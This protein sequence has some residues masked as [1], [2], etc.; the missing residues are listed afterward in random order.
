MIKNKDPFVFW[1]LSGI[2]GAYTR[3]AYSFF[4][5]EIGLAKFYIW[6]V[7][8]SLLIPKAQTQTMPGIILG[9]LIDAVMGGIFGVI[10]GLL[11]EWRGQ[12]NYIVKG[13]GVGLMAWM[14]FY[15][16]LFHNL[17]FTTESAPN[18]PLSNISAFIGHSIFGIAAAVVY[19]KFF[20]KRFVEPTN[21]T[22]SGT[23]HEKHKPMR[24]RLA[25][26]PAKKNEDE[27]KRIRLK[28]PIKLR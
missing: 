24:F 20:S 4:A 5:K 6:Q 3:N 9:F 28:K 11:L 18:D 17:P 10:I 23:E 7:G 27:H 12:K 13:M 22:N 25:P 15:G 2:I 14:F 1:V 26:S 16:I 8:A 21:A 19:V